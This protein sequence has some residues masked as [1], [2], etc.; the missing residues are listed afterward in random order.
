MTERVN[1]YTEVHGDLHSEVIPQAVLRF[2]I[3]TEVIPQTIEN[4]NVIN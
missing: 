3:H 2:D 1:P 4:N